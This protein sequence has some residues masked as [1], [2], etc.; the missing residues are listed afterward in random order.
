[1]KYLQSAI[2]S[3]LIFGSSAVSAAPLAKGEIYIKDV[4]PSH[5]AY[6]AVKEV[7]ED[8]QIM[9]GDG[10]GNFAGYKTMSRYE[11][12]ST[13][14]NLIEFYNEEFAAD[15]QDLSSLASIMEQFQ[16][17]LRILEARLTSLNDK[18][19]L[20]EDSHGEDLSSLK[21]ELAVSK[22]QIDVL[23]ESGFIFDKLIKGTARDVKHVAYGFNHAS[24]KTRKAAKHSML[25]K[26]ITQEWVG[27]ELG[28]DIEVD[29]EVLIDTSSDLNGGY[30][31]EAN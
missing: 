18:L 27:E 24:P 31:I 20:M 4:S 1:M 13:V 30:L 3:A 5:W 10:R 2:I 12:A 15:R 9:K 22:E 7:V 25:E 29:A 19:A 16:E 8:Y 26:P 11:L 23:E 14:N 6:P 17:E 28:S 21:T